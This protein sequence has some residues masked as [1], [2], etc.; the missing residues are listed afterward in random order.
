[1]VLG[2]RGKHF[3][4]RGPRGPDLPHLLGS[5]QDGAVESRNGYAANRPYGAK[6]GNLEGPARAV[7]NR[8]M[9]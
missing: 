3:E 7:W 2:A 5:Y 9:A 1:M 6:E 8:D 4:V